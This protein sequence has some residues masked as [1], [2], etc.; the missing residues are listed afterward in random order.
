MK[1]KLLTSLDDNHEVPVLTCFR[2][3]F[4]LEQFVQNY[5]SH[6][7]LEMKIHVLDEERMR[8]IRR[9]RGT[10]IVIINV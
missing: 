1:L 2:S 5:G 4:G 9:K 8:K 10:N 7:I 3:C 6:V